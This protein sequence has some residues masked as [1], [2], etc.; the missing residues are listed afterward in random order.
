MRDLPLSR[1][2]L[3]TSVPPGG[4][5]IEVVADDA[6]RAALAE[7]FRLVAVKALSGRFLVVPGSA[8]VKVTGTV[9]GTVTQVCTVSLDPFDAPVHEDVD[10]QFMPEGG[11][12]AWMARHRPDPSMDLA[13][14]IDPPDEIVDGRI[15]LGAVTAEF[16]AL[17][18]DPYPRK[19]GIAF[20]QDAES[21][22]KD[23]SPFAILARLKGSDSP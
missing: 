3:V 16:L 14:E 20:E 2:L 10:L 13:Y 6:E 19:P 4:R 8:A 15:D 23:P 11:I 5:E 9:Q 12:T 18:L 22:G 17:G 7:A 21:A 1:P